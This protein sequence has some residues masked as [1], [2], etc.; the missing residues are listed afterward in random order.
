MYVNVHGNMHVWSRKLKGSG[1]RESRGLGKVANV[2]VGL[3]RT[4]VMDVMCF[5]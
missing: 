2:G 1:E 5:N 3:A 4:L